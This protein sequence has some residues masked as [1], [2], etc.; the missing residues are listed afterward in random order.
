MRTIA[1]ALV[2][3]MG[4]IPAVADFSFQYEIRVSMQA[5]VRAVGIKFVGVNFTPFEGTSVGR[6]DFGIEST[7]ACNMRLFWHVWVR[8]GPS[9]RHR[10]YAPRLR[11]SV[12]RAG[13]PR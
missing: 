7:G 5:T 2:L 6:V 12:G 1:A 9:F 11:A 8:I 10:S 4:A 13:K 3:L